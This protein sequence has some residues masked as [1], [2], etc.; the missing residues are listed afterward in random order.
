MKT[1][2]HPNTKWQDV[3]QQIEIDIITGR[4]Q[5]G[6]KVPS[7]AHLVESYDISPATAQKAL[8]NL[9]VEDTVYHKTGVGYYVKQDTAT[10]LKHKYKDMILERLREIVDLATA[11]RIVPDETKTKI[12]IIK[13]LLENQNHGL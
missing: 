3:Q 1:L 11:I 12:G 9:F 10:R 5:S 2:K 6:D 8:H 13:E 4:L 7:L